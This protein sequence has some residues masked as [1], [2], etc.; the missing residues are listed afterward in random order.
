MRIGLVIYGDLD[1]LT[2]GYLYDR[3]LV[4]HLAAAGHEVRVVRLPEG[5]YARRLALNLSWGVRRRLADPDVDLW[6]Q[7]E[8]CHPS[9]LR[10][11]RGRRA[12]DAPV[13][14]LVHQVLCDEPRAGWAN[15]LLAGVEKPYLDSVDGFVFN[16]RTTRD[17]VAVLSPRPRPWVVAPP[18]GDRLGCIPAG[19]D[20][21]EKASAP[22]PLR[23]LFLGNLIPRKGLLPLVDALATLGSD[24]WRLDVAGSSEAD[25]AYARKCAE[26]I[27]AAGLGRRIRLLGPVN[28]PPLAGLLRASHLLCMPFAYEGFG[29]VTLEAMAFGLPVLGSASGATPELVRDGREGILVAP[30]DLAAAAGAVAWLHRDRAALARLGGNARLRF[31]AQARWADT[32]TAVEA[33]FAGMV[34]REGNRPAA[35]CRP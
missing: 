28:G 19:A 22:G 14:A 25:P 23:L 7:D 5:G 17:T 32:M 16:S 4:D 3:I 24:G 20:P 35:P 30:G 21:V 34:R 13:V 9:L 31:D 11:N 26:R 12:R 15:R 10:H 29:I 1:T 27:S 8:L 18:G 2:G 33:F 6:V